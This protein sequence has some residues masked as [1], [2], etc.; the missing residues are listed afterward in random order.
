MSEID[1]AILD[2]DSVI[3]KNIDK[4][5]CSDR[6]FLSQ[7][8]LSQLRNF[9]E[10][11]AMKI[12]SGR[13]DVNPNDYGERK[14]NLKALRSRGDLKFLYKFH[15]L[16]QISASHYTLDEN[17]SERLMLKYYEYLLK[18]K[19]YLAKNYN[20]TVL[21]N[22][23]DFPVDTDKDMQEYHQKI[24]EKIDA[25]SLAAPETVSNERLYIKKI[26]PFF[27]N[28]QIYYEVT[29]T[30]ATDNV[31][32]FDRMIAFTKLDILENYAVKLSMHKD[33]IDIMHSKMKIFIIDSW[34][35]AIRPC[36]IEHFGYI[37]TG[38]SDLKSNNIVYNELMKFISRTNI[39][40]LDL[41]ESSDSFYTRIKEQI[42]TRAKNTSLFDI[43]NSCRTI[44]KEGRPGAN[45]LRYLLYTMNNVIIKS[46][47]DWE[48]PCNNLSSLRLKYGCIPFD[49]MP[50]ATSLCAHNPR[51]YDLLDCIPLQDREHEFFARRVR[52]NT[53]QHDILFTK[54]TDLTSFQ[55][56]NTLIDTYNN[57]LYYKHIETRSLKKFSDN[58]FINEYAEDCAYI[59]T[60]LKEQAVSG[61]GKYT[62]SVTAWL[63]SNP[64][65]IDDETKK[66]AILKMFANSHVSFIYGSAG[67]GKSTLIRHISEFLADKSKIYLANTN[68]A[69]DNL[70][71]KVKV[72]NCEYMTI[73][74]FLTHEIRNS[75]YDI[76]FID[77]CSTVCNS[78]MRKILEEAKFKLLV[79]VGDIYQIEAIQFGNWFSIAKRFV[80]E[81]SVFELTNTFRSTDEN[82]KLLWT[83]VR[84][85]DDNIQEA[86]EKYGYSERLDN[87]VFERYDED[88]I[89]LCLNYDGLYGIN[90]INL[91]LQGNNRNR[92]VENGVHTYK[93]GDPILFNESNRFT[94]V[95]YNNMKG[96][97]RNIVEDEDYITF[98]I[99]IDAILNEMDV[100]GYDFNLLENAESGNSVI[101]FSVDKRIDTDNDNSHSAMP[102][103]IAYAISIHKAQGLEYNSVKII[104]SN[105]TE[106]Q[107]SHNIFYTAITR[108][109]KNLKIY[110]SP[111][112]E[113][114]VLS[115]LK[116]KTDGNHDANIL[117][118]M[119]SL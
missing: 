74:K 29:F 85:L 57:N 69:V 36:E 30:L 84:N 56:I 12:C 14:I 44:I 92:G 76:L 96:Y 28:G 31:S 8:I 91:F 78:D 51:I 98:D 116:K 60:R 17:A 32:K 87:N 68:P 71:R 113:H 77:E 42:I 88:E 115:N 46:Q 103:Q 16:L 25:Y 34:E 106:E 2:T 67:T 101:R 100:S 102:F 117:K 79:L 49:T 82:L 47:I 23:A 72:A 9:V 104:I 41:I 119:Y 26:K 58:V 3:C 11:I 111:E 18:I 38:K 1:K 20:L 4:F 15:S 105:E 35:V 50:F 66:N 45:V 75:E 114:H 80:P 52:T 19:S 109:R 73:A 90:N 65:L 43:F 39:N 108:A 110:W 55:N 24:A 27:V 7:N 33:V 70:K 107:I 118:S 54:L 21:Q 89:I 64:N 37:F 81:T 112:V 62:E 40:L 53:E 83:R 6:G 99:E 86:I 10:Y 93:I 94:P 5:G 61:V 22:I 48:K 13:D 63:Q 59:I 97:I 95:I